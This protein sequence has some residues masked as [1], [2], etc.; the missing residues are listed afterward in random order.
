MKTDL[1]LILDT[2][3]SVLPNSYFDLLG[4]AEIF[5]GHSL[6]SDMIVASSKKVEL[7]APV[8]KAFEIGIENILGKAFEHP[9]PLLLS[10]L[11]QKRFATKD[12][13]Y[14]CLPHTMRGCQV[15]ADLAVKLSGS[16]IS[17]V[18][19]ITLGKDG[20]LFKRNVMNGKWIAS[21]VPEKYPVIFTVNQGAFADPEKRYVSLDGDKVCGETIDDSSIEY[22]S[23]NLSA[24]DNGD[25]SIE[26]ASVVVGAGRGA[27]DEETMELVHEFATHFKNS[28]VGASRPLCD[29]G[30][31]PYSHQIGETG[32][33]IA[34]KVYI[35]CGIS[36]SNQH[37]AGIRQAQ[38]I[39]AINKDPQAAIFRTADIGIVE[40]VEDIIPEL[41]KLLSGV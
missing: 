5:E 18:E 12:P 34:P 9:N 22:V 37:I 33:Q 23:L 32:K 38:T 1:L 8:D 7:K 40:E 36:G 29:S 3:E 10:G 20:P 15:A 4:V 21:I 35:A 24:A 19:A 26:E 17:G 25:N 2:I 11:I 41:L 28:A 16:L 30:V 39:V 6:K 14:I 31:F 27:E 13:K